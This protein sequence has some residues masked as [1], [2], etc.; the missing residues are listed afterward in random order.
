MSTYLMNCSFPI[1]KM[2]TSFPWMILCAGVSAVQCLFTPV[3]VCGGGA[4][5]CVHLHRPEVDARYLSLS[6]SPLI[7]EM[8]SLTGPKA[9]H[10][11]K[12]KEPRSPRNFP[13]SVPP[14]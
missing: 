13:F 10:L 4:W 14:C 7:F 1:P 2:K 5:A 11:E 3:Y 6:L 8:G 12:T 9:H